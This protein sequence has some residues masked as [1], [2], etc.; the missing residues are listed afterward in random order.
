MQTDRQTDRQ[1]E[2]KRERSELLAN[3]L[4][5]KVQYIGSLKRSSNG[6]SMYRTCAH[7]VRPNT[8]VA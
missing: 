6:W 2:R 8:Q 5:Y 1:T 7:M 3:S 4:P